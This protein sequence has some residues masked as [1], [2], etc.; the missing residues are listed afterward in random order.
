MLKKPVTEVMTARLSVRTYREAPI[1][2]EAELRL[3]EFIAGLP[4]GPFG[5]KPRFRLVAAGAG[6]EDALRGLGT[7]G[8]IRRPAGFVVGAMDGSGGRPEDFG[9]LMEMIVLKAT[10]LGLGT[11][12][13]GGTFRKSR[14][15]AAVGAG[16]G[17]TVPAVV[18]VGVPVEKRSFRDKLIRRVAGS[19]HRM[20]WDR[21][22]FS[23]AFA[24]PLTAEAAGA[25]AVP[26]EMVRLAPSASNKQPWRVVMA[27][28]EPVFHFF[29]HGSKGLDR[30][31][32]R[33]A[34]A[35]GLQRVDLGIAMC[36]FELAARELKLAGAWATADPGIAALP[37]A[38]EHV[39]TW[40]G[41]SGA[42]IPRPGTGAD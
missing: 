11:C 21:L 26:L 25:Y 7:Y 40:R 34:D 9:C 41:E 1:G 10:E 32:D 15:A 17:E 27:P 3:N 18:S 16:E 19:D 29:L 24:E 37:A 31:E 8:M 23:G 4:A 36:H 33:I 12:W 5:T 39:A 22:F 28:E 2:P 30:S 13:L 38:T 35:A 42:A 20:P 6:D 14:F